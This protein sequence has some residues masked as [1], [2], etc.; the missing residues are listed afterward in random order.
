MR[1]SEQGAFTALP[2]GGRT[3]ATKLKCVE[4]FSDPNRVSFI[5]PFEHHDV[6]VD[7]WRVPLLQAFPQGEDEVSLVLDRRIAVT[8]KGTD[9]IER[10]LPFIA[11]T[12]A[13]ALGYGSHPRQ[14]TERPLQWQPLHPRP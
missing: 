9:E 10:V 13:V 2:A 5:G 4:D 11:D 14:D 6:V 1:H 7:G 8:L 12:I 3:P